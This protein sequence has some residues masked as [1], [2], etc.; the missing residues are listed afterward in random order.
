MDI[1]ILA[2]KF[3]QLYGFG[4]VRTFFSPNRVN[5]IGE[6]IDYN[7][8]HV[9]PCAIQ[10]GT[11]GCV[12]KRSDNKVRL[13]STNSRLKAE[14]ELDDLQYDNSNQWANYPKGVIWALQKLGYKISGMDILVS[15]ELPYGIGLSSS[16]SLELLIAMMI[17]NLFNEGSIPKLELIKASQEAENDFVG[18][19]CG[20]MDQFAVC[21]GVKNKAIL[22]DCS[23]LA[24]KYADVN[25]E[26]YLLVIMNTNKVRELSDSKYNERRAECEEALSILKRYKDIENLCQINREEFSV[27]EKYIDDEKIKNRAKHVILENERVLK[28]YDTF[29]KGD[30]E[31]AGRLLIE[32]HASLRDL[33]EVTGKELDLIVDL[34]IDNDKCVG[35]R[36]IGAG[37]GGCAIAIVQKDGINDFVNIVG[38]KY[39]RIIGYNADFYISEIGEGTRE[40]V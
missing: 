25:L 40:I 39:E 28:A 8:G 4:E 1:D 37:F 36:M 5:L 32:S 7:G 27:L 9:L 33:Y 30:A 6:H 16:A 2:D 21:L 10:F 11:Y 38:E 22:L 26:D 18:V 29:R 13:A 20:I 14:F 3:R 31:K 19:K 35:A 15:G 23:S 24:Y 34:A 17:N 12:R